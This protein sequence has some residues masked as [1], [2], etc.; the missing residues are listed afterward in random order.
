MPRMKHITGT[1]AGRT[2]VDAGTREERVAGSEKGSIAYTDMT[3]VMQTEGARTHVKAHL[4]AE[5]HVVITIER[6]LLGVRDSQR[7]ATVTVSGEPV[8]L[9]RVTVD[10]A[11]TTA[12]TILRDAADARVLATA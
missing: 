10:V 1:L 12:A 8:A 5:G 3:A 11:T 7:L 4:D 2:V 6:R 9:P